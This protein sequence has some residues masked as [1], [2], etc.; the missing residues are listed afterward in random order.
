[1]SSHEAKSQAKQNSDNV[2]GLLLAF[3]DKAK[4]I[5]SVR[6]GRQSGRDLA[7]SRRGNG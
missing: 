7:N 1:M 4:A 5:V 3:L 6:L 2:L